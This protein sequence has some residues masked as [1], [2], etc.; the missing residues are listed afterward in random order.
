MRV[1]ERFSSWPFFVVYR[2]MLGVVILI[3]AATGWL[4]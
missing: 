3:G 2:F 1:L 4:N